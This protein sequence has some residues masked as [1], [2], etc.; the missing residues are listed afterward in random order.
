MIST[1][2]RTGGSDC[3]RAIPLGCL[4]QGFV[5]AAKVVIVAACVSLYRIRE[6]AN[7]LQFG[8]CRHTFWLHPREEKQPLASG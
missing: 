6:S 8:I 5:A 3:I 2:S 1:V 4:P 7:D